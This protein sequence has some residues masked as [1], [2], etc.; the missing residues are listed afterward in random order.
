MQW[1]HDYFLGQVGDVDKSQVFFVMLTNSIIDAKRIKM[2][3][4]QNKMMKNLN[5]CGAFSSGWWVET[6]TLVIE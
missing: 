2:S 6:D 1:Q 4:S 5:N 3:S